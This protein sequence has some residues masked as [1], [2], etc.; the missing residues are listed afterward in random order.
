MAHGSVP[1]TMGSP[2]FR[3]ASVNGCGVVHAWFPPES[4]IEF[5]THEH[6][7]F[8]VMLRGSFDLAFRQRTFSCTP[9]CVAVE[10]AGERHAN[11]I[12]ARGADVLVL[13]PAAQEIELWRPFAPLFDSIGYL[14]HGGIAGLAGKLVHELSAPD[15]WSGLA[16]EGLMLDMLVA[17]SRVRAGSRKEMVPSW[18]GRIEAMLHEEPLASIDIAALARE[19]SVHPAYLARVFRRYYHSSIGEYG[20]RIRLEQVAHQLRAGE[21]PIASIASQAGFSDQS[22]L[23]RCFR[24]FYGVTPGEF[25]RRAGTS[26]PL[27]HG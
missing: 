11:Y 2:Q 6:A 19:A 22:H 16:M 27:Q 9:S 14:R 15:P 7:T 4:T 13:Q 8:A 18:L 26:P 24:K 12:G 21:T 1:V 20:R 3:H 23:T 5:H 25:R 10:P 17:A